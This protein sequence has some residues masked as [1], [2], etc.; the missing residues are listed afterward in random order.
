[1][2]SNALT[3]IRWMNGFLLFDFLSQSVKISTVWWC[4]EKSLGAFYG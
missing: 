4:N 3:L 2:N 1:M